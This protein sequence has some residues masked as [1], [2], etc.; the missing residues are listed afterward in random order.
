[1]SHLDFMSADEFDAATMTT[2]YIES[3]VRHTRNNSETSSM[4]DANDL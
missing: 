2:S 1:M 3:G 4:V